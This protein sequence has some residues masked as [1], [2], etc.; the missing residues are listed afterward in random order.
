M[1]LSDICRDNLPELLKYRDLSNSL[2]KSYEYEA[3]A[4]FSAFLGPCVVAFQLFYDPD[5]LITGAA[6]MF[7]VWG[8]WFLFIYQA[9]LRKNCFK[10]GERL[11]RVFGKYDLYL[12]GK[13]AKTMSGLGLYSI[14]ERTMNID[15]IELGFRA[16]GVSHA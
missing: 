9:T 13:E 12:A 4:K 3:G 14:N 16:K 2:R 11:I 15:P 10:L 5:S 8:W 6:L 7:S 1:E